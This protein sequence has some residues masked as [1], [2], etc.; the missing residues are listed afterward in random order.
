LQW[1]DLAARAVAHRDE[2]VIKL[3]DACLHEDFIRPDPIYRA[4]A[5]AIQRCLPAWS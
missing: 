5:E 1:D 3:T 2:H 4:V